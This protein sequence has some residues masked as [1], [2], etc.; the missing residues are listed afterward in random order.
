MIIMVRGRECSPAQFSTH[1]RSCGS[2][3]IQ[4]CYAGVKANGLLTVK[5][6][7]TRLTDSATVLSKSAAHL[8]AGSTHD[9]RLL[10]H[11]ALLLEQF[12]SPFSWHCDCD[13][14]AGT[15]EAL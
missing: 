8:L 2:E 12:P 4:G 1:K 11:E 14:Q 15:G 5:V 9:D 7:L 6:T 10:L 13:V 3:L